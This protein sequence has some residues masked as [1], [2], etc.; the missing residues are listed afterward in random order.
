MDNK[1]H[2]K[3]LESNVEIVENLSNY[4]INIEYF[5]FLFQANIRVK[6]SNVILIEKILEIEVPLEVNTYKQKN[7]FSLLCLG[8]DEWLFVAP[9]E[10][11]KKIMLDK[12]Y[13]NDSQFIS[14]VDVSFNRKIIR[15]SGKNILKLFSALTSFQVDKM[16]DRACSNT[17]LAKSQVILQC[18]KEKEIYN[19]FV[20]SSFSRYLVDAIIDQSK[21]FSNCYD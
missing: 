9:L 16:S 6:K 14:F 5:G 4:G 21:F 7:N 8:P 15:M 3:S 17:M 20:R 18:I 13:K 10:Q 12:I 1:M 11:R 19:I 2:I